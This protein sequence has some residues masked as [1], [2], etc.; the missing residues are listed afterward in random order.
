MVTMGIKFGDIMSTVMIKC[1]NTGLAVST[2]IE[3]EQSV[4]RRLPRVASRMHCPA[5]GQEHVW[6]TSSAWLS[7]GPRLIETRKEPAAA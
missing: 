2:A 3:T 6:L 7:G 4:F 1:P 5:C